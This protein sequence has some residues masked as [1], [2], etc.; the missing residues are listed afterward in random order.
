MNNLKAI[1][2]YLPQFHPVPENDLWWGKGFPEWREAVNARKRHNG[3]CQSPPG[4]FVFI[5]AWNEWAE[6]NHLEP[7]LRWGTQYL[8][9]TLRALERDGGS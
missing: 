9:Q 6:G 1:A 3:H 4:Q 2:I 5:N 8:Q 7:D